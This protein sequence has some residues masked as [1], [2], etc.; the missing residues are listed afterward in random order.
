MKYTIDIGSAIVFTVDDVRVRVVPR[1]YVA[2]DAYTYRRNTRV[3]VSD[4]LAERDLTLAAL[5][6]A[7]RNLGD[8][9][10]SG[11][12]EDANV[13]ALYDALNKR[14]ADVKRNVVTSV[15]DRIKN[16]LY[17]TQ[18]TPDVKA[19]FSRKGGCSCG[20][21]PAVVLNHVLTSYY[22]PTDIWLDLDTEEREEGET[23]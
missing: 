7:E 18:H 6:N 22:R 8:R 9:R 14:I 12:G 2:D 3:Y 19:R 10:F 17:G 21:S 23:R 20:C 15:I 13:D 16:Q 4:E 1:V 5:A 11:R